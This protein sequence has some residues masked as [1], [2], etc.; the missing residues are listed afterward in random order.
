MFIMVMAWLYGHN[1]WDNPSGR[2]SFEPGVPFLNA[3]Q[4]MKTLGK[5]RKKRNKSAT[6]TTDLM[7][8]MMDL[9]IGRVVI[10]RRK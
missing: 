1:I 5:G 6:A 2:T 9:K 8:G 7:L 4:I 3:L 10:S